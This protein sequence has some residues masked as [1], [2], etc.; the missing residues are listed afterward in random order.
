MHACIAQY[1]C[2]LPPQATYTWILLPKAFNVSQGAV[3][4]MAVRLLDSSRQSYLGHLAARQVEVA[5]VISLPAQLA[6]SWEYKGK[7]AN[8]QASTDQAR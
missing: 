7:A 3:E 2:L 6:C 5:L 1:A 8:S 4:H